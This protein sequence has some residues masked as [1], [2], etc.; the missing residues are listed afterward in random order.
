MLAL[1]GEELPSLDDASLRTPP[2]PAA[3]ES[4]QNTLNFHLPFSKRIQFSNKILPLSHML[5]QYHDKDMEAL[6]AL[7][8]HLSV[9]DS[10]GK[11]G[12]STT[13]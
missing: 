4:I 3:I 6:T 2:K 12:G 9:K 10:P 8:S 7:S 1:L 13:V 11:P 5:V